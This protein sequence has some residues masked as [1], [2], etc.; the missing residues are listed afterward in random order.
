MSDPASLCSSGSAMRGTRKM[1]VELFQTEL[2]F[3]LPD[4]VNLDRLHDL[5][6]T[7]YSDVASVSIGIC[8]PPL[9]VLTFS[10]LPTEEQVTT[11]KRQIEAL[12]K[13]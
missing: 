4:D 12:M 1:K 11:M 3:S 8:N 10:D 7:Q 13:I 6:E 9:I 5:L 2:A